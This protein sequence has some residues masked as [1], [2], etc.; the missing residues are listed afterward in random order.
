MFIFGCGLVMLLL[1]ASSVFTLIFLVMAA[2]LSM[3][4]LHMV[5]FG[6]A[7]VNSFAF[8]HGFRV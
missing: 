5:M 3:C 2:L 4:C 6:P 7:L 8:F 1:F